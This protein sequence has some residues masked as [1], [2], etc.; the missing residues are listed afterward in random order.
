MSLVGFTTS[1]MSVYLF[2]PCHSHVSDHGAITMRCFIK[3]KG[4]SCCFQTLRSESFVDIKER[5][6]QLDMCIWRHFPAGS[7]NP[8]D[9]WN[10]WNMKKDNVYTDLGYRVSNVLYQHDRNKHFLFCLYDF[11]CVMMEKDVCIISYFQLFL[12]KNILL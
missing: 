10:Y 6:K 12:F 8:P 7:N 11:N 5:R 3:T 9:I 1:E 2:S 4:K